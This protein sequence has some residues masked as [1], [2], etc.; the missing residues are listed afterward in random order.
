MVTDPVTGHLLDYGTRQY[1]PDRLRRFVLARDG[2]CIAPDCTTRSPRRL[3]M[4]HVTPYP[5][6]RS[7]AANC[8]TKCITCHQL[9]T[10]NRI[11]VTDSHPDGS[12]TWTTRWGQTVRIPAD[13]VRRLVALAPA[14]LTLG[15]RDNPEF[16]LQDTVAAGAGAYYWRTVEFKA[17]N[18]PI[19]SYGVMLGLSLVVGWY[20]TLTLAERDGL[21]KEVM[22]N[23]Y[24][25]TAIAAIAAASSTW[26]T[27]CPFPVVTASK[28]WLSLISWLLLGLTA[29]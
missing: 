29:P 5:Q 17:E 6:G 16:H 13:V 7:S 9:K 26:L 10:D 18:V 3:Q 11:R 2:G 15:A 4:D 12:R 21:P 19:Y 28:A 23:C 8:D 27:A 1:L 20:L 14:R 24:V 22:A 25:V